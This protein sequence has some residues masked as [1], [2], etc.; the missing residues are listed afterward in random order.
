MYNPYRRKE[1]KMKNKFI[2]GLLVVLSL[3]F[4]SRISV[5][6]DNGS[7]TILLGK[8]NL[9]VLSGEV[10]GDSVGALIVKAK[11]MDN[12]LSGRF[13]SSK[14]PIY[15]YMNTPGGS[16]QSGLELI[17]MLKGLGRPV[18]TITEF[19]ASMGWQIVQSMDNRYVLESAILM[20]HR[21]AGQF[22]GSFGGESP[23]QLDQRI[24]LFVQITKELDQQTVR[25]TNGKQTLESYQ[26]AYASELW[27]TGRESIEAGYADSIVKIK[28]DKSLSGTTQY[29]TEFLGVPISYELDNCP[30][31]TAPL[32]IK[33]GAVPGMTSEY[34]NQVKKEFLSN[35]NMKMSTPLPM[36]Y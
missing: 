19:S 24:R 16:V 12:V 33:V 10:N 3:A 21:A 9:L 7:E 1:K 32:N 18:H 36:V 27:L 14:D 11:E 31:N 13:G 26:R 6:K 4:V 34:I 5:S 8:N 23:S 22:G 28:C 2:V 29:R 15:L 25:R 20:S 30:I 17:E 35:Y